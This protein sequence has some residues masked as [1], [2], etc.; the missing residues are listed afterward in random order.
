MKKFKKVIKVILLSLLVLVLGG[1]VVLYI[2]NKELASEIFDKVVYYLNKPL[3]IVGVS[4]VILSLLVWKIF[5]STIY[6]KK[7]IAEMKSEFE[8]EKA[9]LKNQYE[10]KKIEYA[11]VLDCYR[12][13]NDLVYEAVEKVCDAIPNVKVKEIGVALKSDVGLVREEL[14]NL[15]KEVSNANA[16]L[17][18][19]SKEQI[20][21][22][23]V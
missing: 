15:S 20:I 21:D 4:A 9:E 7:K 22:S 5:S 12:K 19:E 3:P 16:E 6:G 18:L 17:L 8:R 11:A 14:K 10:A 23:I 1:I 2:V 13:E